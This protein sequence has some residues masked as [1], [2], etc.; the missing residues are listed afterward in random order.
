MSRP[1]PLGGG[2]G[3]NNSHFSACRASPRTR[4]HNWPH[5]PSLNERSAHNSYDFDDSAGHELLDPPHHGDGLA[6]A[7]DGGSR[8]LSSYRNIEAS[9]LPSALTRPGSR[10]HLH[11]ASIDNYM[12][13][14]RA[15]VVMMTGALALDGMRRARSRRFDPARNMSERDWRGILALFMTAEAKLLRC[16]AN[17]AVTGRRP[18]S[19]AAP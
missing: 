2:F 14:A 18:S 19:M 7:A 6:G 12:S 3:A 15:D 10:A 16:C 4:R 13:G 8:W 17:Y 5:Q 11:V 1:P 9:T